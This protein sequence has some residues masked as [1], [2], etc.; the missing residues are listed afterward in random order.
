MGVVKAAQR[1][2][3]G[4][5]SI[6]TSRRVRIVA[7]ALVLCAVAFVLIQVHSIWH[8]SQIDLGQVN[9]PLIVG[10]GVLAAAAVVAAGYVWLQILRR[11]GVEVRQRWVAIFLETQLGKY[12]PGSV[13][14]YA[15]RTALTRVEGVAVGTVALSV[16]VELAVSVFAG[17]VVASL[18]LGA[19]GIIATAV[20]I[21]SAGLAVSRLEI[22]RLQPL[23]RLAPR[24]AAADVKRALQATVDGTAL[25]VVI[26][27]MLAAAFW[28]TAHA[29]FSV[30]IAQA[31]YYMGVYGTACLVGLIAIFAPV[32][33]GVR[34]ALIV[35]LLRSRLGT[36]DALV[37]AA[38]SRL[39]LTIVDLTTAAVG[40]VL[41]RRRRL[42]SAGEYH[43]PDS[44]RRA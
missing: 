10:A 1:F 8:E 13:W 33:F 9:W 19:A 7:Q 35:A 5:A 43:E 42:V 12:I 38:S 6:V 39:L 36:A 3:M 41:L 25:Y 21:S 32:G 14:H 26:W 20:L 29:L 31:P 27:F 11:L 34:E 28:L 2:V 15:G 37:L 24:V 16:T 30:P 44:A 17:L 18:I 22:R 40:V 4:R 23:G